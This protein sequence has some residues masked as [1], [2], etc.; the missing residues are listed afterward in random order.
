ME[1]GIEQPD[2]DRQ[3]VHDFEDPL[4]VAA[5]DREQLR[6]RLATPGFIRGDDHLTHQRDTVTLEEHVFGPAQPDPLGAEF[7]RP[8]GV[9]RD[10]GV[11]PDPQPALGVG[12]RHQS[13]EFLSDLRRDELGRAQNDPARRAVDGDDLATLH[14]PAVYPELAGGR[15][16]IQLLG[17]HDTRLAHTAR[18][19]R[20]VTRHAA[21]RSEN[22]ARCHHAVEVL[23]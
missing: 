14:R 5:L 6:E 13:I 12:P 15:I 7:A 1:R 23:G 11:G 19:H 4:E 16:D 18:Y 22:R 2:R 9:S 3:P 17:A 20:R 8:A 21:A 10:V